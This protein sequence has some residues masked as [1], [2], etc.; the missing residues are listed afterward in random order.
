MFFLIHFIIIKKLV[1]IIK[2][3]NNNTF[4]K[5]QELLHIDICGSDVALSN[6]NIVY[7]EGEVA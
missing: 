1:I 5:N 4:F 3:L 2:K 6:S 7:E